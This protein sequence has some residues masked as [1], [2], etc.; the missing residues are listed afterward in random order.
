MKEVT[1]LL[2]GIG[3]G[4]ILAKKGQENKVL[5]AKLEAYQSAA[6]KYNQQ[7]GATQ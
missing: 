6:C 4:F 5:K 2:V 3:I 1:L 7:Q